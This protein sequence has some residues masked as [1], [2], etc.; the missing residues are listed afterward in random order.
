MINGS[1]LTGVTA[2]NISG[3]GVTA[4]NLRGFGD[5]TQMEANFAVSSNA[6]V[7]PRDITV[8][9]LAGMSAPLIGGFTVNANTGLPI[10]SIAGPSVVPAGG[11]FDINVSGSKLT[12]IC[13]WQFD[14]QYDNTVF[15]VIGTEGGAGVTPGL[16]GITTMPVDMW[17][18]QPPGTASGKIRVLG[19]I[20]VPRYVNGMGYLAQ[21]HFAVLGAM[22]HIVPYTWL[23]LS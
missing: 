4:S 10:V 11:K 17:A 2:V 7:G 16:V 15:Q 20:G 13:G 9:T 3:T 6:T 8:T 22:V 21:I 12:N 23:T 1:D 14:L 5:G 18:F 19:G